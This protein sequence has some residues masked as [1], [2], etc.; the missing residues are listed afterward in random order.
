MCIETINSRQILKQNV[1]PLPSGCHLAKRGQDPKGLYFVRT[2]TVRATCI[3]VCENF[4]PS[5][6]AWISVNSAESTQKSAFTFWGESSLMVGVKGMDVLTDV[7]MMPYHVI[8]FSHVDL[9]VLTAANFQKLLRG[10]PGLLPI[11]RNIQYRIAKKMSEDMNAGGAGVQ[12]AAAAA[13]PPSFDHRQFISNMRARQWELLA[14]R[15]KANA[16]GWDETIA[17]LLVEQHR[18]A[19]SNSEYSLHETVDEEEWTHQESTHNLFPIKSRMQIRRSISNNDLKHK[20]IEDPVARASRQVNEP[21]QPDKQVVTKSSKETGKGKK[22]V[23]VMRKLQDMTDEVSALQ[24]TIQA[25]SHA[26]AQSHGMH[27]E[28]NKRT[29]EN[30]TGDGDIGSGHM[31]LPHANKQLDWARVAQQHHNAYSEYIADEH[32]CPPVQ[33]FGKEHIEHAPSPASNCEALVEH[34]PS[35]V[36]HVKLHENAGEFLKSASCLF[37]NSPPAASSP[38]NTENLG[39]DRKL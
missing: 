37:R 29:H 9:V 1:C 7:L 27:F 35:P 32:H 22:R 8:S 4:D 3:D 23:L 31:G 30:Q 14:D 11:F 10:F 36:W 16:G 19:Q 21:S 5:P 18:K 6:S 28:T 13:V 39:T 12:V 25:L 34:T 17:R 2:G 20:A 15:L 24:E 33:F 26:V 38:P